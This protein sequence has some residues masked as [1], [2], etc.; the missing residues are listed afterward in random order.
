MD[1]GRGTGAKDWHIITMWL[2]SLP[3]LLLS[4]LTVDLVKKIK[5]CVV[6]VPVQCTSGCVRSVFLVVPG[7][8]FLHL[9]W[10]LDNYNVWCNCCSVGTSQPV[11]ICFIAYKARCI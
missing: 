1:R 6:Y 7:N 2:S 5:S 3:S 4:S 9:R 11:Y 8:S 10:T